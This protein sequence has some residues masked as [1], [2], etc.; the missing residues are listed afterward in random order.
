MLSSATESTL[1]Q[2]LTIGTG[3]VTQHLCSSTIRHA[4]S[5][6]REV[7]AG[8]RWRERGGGVRRTKKRPK[9]EKYLLTWPDEVMLMDLGEWKCP[10]SEN[11]EWEER[12][13]QQRGGERETEKGRLVLQECRGRWHLSFTHKHVHTHH[14]CILWWRRSRGE[15][16]PNS[17]WDGREWATVVCNQIKETADW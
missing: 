2:Q 13:I 1:R 7:G 5:K 16:T 6:Q 11:D 8:G 14:R 4:C 12:E 9:R 17:S 15:K 10:W 3:T